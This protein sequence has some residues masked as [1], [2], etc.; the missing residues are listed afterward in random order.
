MR[1]VVRG[2]VSW[3]SMES[4]NLIYVCVYNIYCCSGCFSWKV[5]LYLSEPVCDNENCVKAL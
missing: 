5:V 3:E 1:T 4:P 2:D